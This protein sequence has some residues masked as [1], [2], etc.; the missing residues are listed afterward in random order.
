MQIILSFM[1]PNICKKEILT[2]S[3]ILLRETT[4]Y[5]TLE[6]DYPLSAP[7]ESTTL[8]GR[9]VWVLTQCPKIPSYTAQRKEPKNYSTPKSS[10]IFIHKIK[11]DG[12][13]FYCEVSGYFYAF[14]KCLGLQRNPC[15]T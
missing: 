5:L 10:S 9:G 13:L 7:T 15:Y 1:I 2:Y 4:S 14:C 6:K 3:T 8:Y 11:R 12:F